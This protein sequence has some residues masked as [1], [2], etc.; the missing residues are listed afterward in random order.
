MI[1][2][3]LQASN[4][5]ELSHYEETWKS[6]PITI[7]VADP[8]ISNDD[9]FTVDEWV[10]DLFTNEEPIKF[11]D[12][13]AAKDFNEAKQI[14]LSTPSAELSL[15]EYVKD[16]QVKMQV[17]INTVNGNKFKNPLLYGMPSL[18]SDKQLLPDYGCVITWKEGYDESIFEG[19]DLVCLIPESKAEDYDNGNGEADLVFLGPVKFTNING[20]LV[21]GGERAEYQC[22]LKIAGTYTGGEL[23]FTTNKGKELKATIG[24]GPRILKANVSASTAE[25]AK[26]KLTA[27][28]EDANHGETTLSFSTMGNPTLVSGQCITISG[29]GI[30]DGKYYLNKVTH[31]VGAAYTTAFECSRVRATSLGNFTTTGASGK[32]SQN[33]LDTL[34]W[35]TRTQAAISK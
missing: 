10:Y 28:I 24:A 23:T 21:Q 4:E 35:A 19:E 22:T 17:L 5:A 34:A 32:Q 8:L 2:C 20:E 30:A 12:V 27:A 9:L 18:S 1:I 26:Q 3:A 31:T 14:K 7:T 11:Y 15:A 33:K 6:V 13:S 25:E 16:V 29:L